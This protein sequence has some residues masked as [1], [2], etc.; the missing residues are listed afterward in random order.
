[1]AVFSRQVYLRTSGSTNDHAITLSN[2][3]P[4]RNTCTYTFNQV[5]G[6][7]QIG[8]SWYTG[9]DKNLA[10]TFSWKQPDIPILEQ[11][12][13]NMAFSLAVWS[14]AAQH[15]SQEHLTIKWPND[16]YYK[17]QKLAGILIQN[18]LK[19]STIEVCHLGVGLNINEQDFPLDI[20]NPVSLRQITGQSYKLVEMQLQLT[21]IVSQHLAN[22]NG[23]PAEL[24]SAYE[25]LLYRKGQVK[26]FRVD[27]QVVSGKIL[28]TTSE[29]KLRL[30]LEEGIKEFGFR[31][32][33]YV[34]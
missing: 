26:A 16:I 13:I 3:D 15:T 20:P 5:A 32:M 27:E 25:D 21:E 17:N 33:G 10:S 7:G 22:L 4:N 23:D 6:R 19:G 11:F 2:N 1:M 29:G 24:K 12:R 14:F 9:A 18:V 30:E 34:I 31:E 8:R 28:G